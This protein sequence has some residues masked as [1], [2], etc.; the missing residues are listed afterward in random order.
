MPSPIRLSLVAAL[1]LAVAAQDPRA[2]SAGLISASAS[3]F[4]SASGGRALASSSPSPT[5]TEFLISGTSRPDSVGALAVS[6]ATEPIPTTAAAVSLNTQPC[7]LYIEFCERTYGEI[8]QVGTHNSP[9]V[10]PNNAAANQRLDVE[11]QLNDG[12][13]LLQ[14]QVHKVNGTLSFCH[15]SCDLLNAG[16]VE[17]YLRR[18][19]RWL[20]DNPFEVVTILLANGAYLPVEEYVAP[21]EVHPFNSVFM[22]RH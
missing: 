22:S 7:N 4:A 3:H 20:A 2:T 19:V 16:P 8:T 6:N 17:T 12:V 9:F 14:G 5:P 18:V 11:A 15:T 13:R 21:I 10:R 1:C